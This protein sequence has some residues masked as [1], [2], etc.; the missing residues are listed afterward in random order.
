MKI[1]K[2]QLPEIIFSLALFVVF[3]SFLAFYFIDLQNL[4]GT[5]DALFSTSR[6]YFF[7]TYEPFFFHHWGRNSGLA[8]ILQWSFLG[9]STI[10][11]AFIAGKTSFTNRKLSAFWKIISIA[12]LLMLLEDAGNLRHVLMSYVQW[13]FNEP[14]QEFMGTLTELIYFSILGGI[15]LY[16]LIR[17]WKEIKVFTK[18]KIYFIIGFVFYA[19][20]ASLSFLGTAFEGLL[21]IN[22]YTFLG[23]NL[24]EFSLSIGDPG[25]EKYWRESSFN[26]EFFLMDSLIEENI[27]IIGAG[28]LLAA[29]LSFFLYIRNR[30][31]K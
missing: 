19:I 7:F 29:S 22:L 16:A 14:D 5:R 17:Y 21:P 24:Y 26:I 18:T 9:G 25:L 3:F 11:A 23:R 28:A 30:P 27:E 15:P 4:W 10:M 20:G 12:F 6:A 13:M 8:E 1:K 2:I 31:L